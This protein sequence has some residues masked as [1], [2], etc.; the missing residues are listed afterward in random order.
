[1]T[2]S[3]QTFL[4]LLLFVI[5][6]LVGVFFI[7]RLICATF[8]S[9]VSI[10][11]RKHPVI[12]IIWGC[13]AVFGLLIF[14]GI[15][16]PNV[17]PPTSI[18]RHEQREEVLKR[19]QSAGGWEAVRLGCEALS[20]NYPDRYFWRQIRSNLWISI[21]RKT[22][23]KFD[24]FTNLDYEL[25][26][27]AIAALHPIEIRLETP[28]QTHRVGDDSKII[29]VSVRIFGM[30]GAHHHLSPYYGLAVPCGAG[31]E[32]YELQMTEEGPIGNRHSSVRKVADGVFEI[33]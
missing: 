3:I 19:V 20:T 7:A 6:P 17:W 1:M 9:K 33:Y 11:M 27:A 32:H 29:I 26:P 2:T 18:E 24:S 22:E 15:I 13:F 16:N 28:E 31:A 4:T 14:L 30:A 8:S 25:F 10:Q 12:H 23:S 5:C 21:S